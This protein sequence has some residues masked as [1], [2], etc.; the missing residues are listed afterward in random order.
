MLPM[1]AVGRHLT[2]GSTFQRSR[3]SRYPTHCS[4][5]FHSEVEGS[6]PY[7]AQ[8]KAPTH[9]YGAVTRRAWA[10]T[11]PEGLTSCLAQETWTACGLKYGSIGFSSRAM[12]PEQSEGR[13]CEKDVNSCLS[14]G[15]WLIHAALD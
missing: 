8:T 5:S 9:W 6:I 11:L 2:Q 3:V 10:H 15:P 12:D 14:F 1:L 7:L 4:P 13:P